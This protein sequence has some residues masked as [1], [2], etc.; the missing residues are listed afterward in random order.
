MNGEDNKLVASH[1]F[2]ASTLV[3]ADIG[4]LDFASLLLAIVAILFG[5][6]SVFAYFNFRSL[7][8]AHAREEAESI[9]AKIAEKR[10][11]SYL[12]AELPKLVDEY[13]ELVKS[14]ADDD[15]ADMIA[16]AQDNGELVD[17]AEDP[18]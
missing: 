18:K 15:I 8:K 16:Q 17:G 10:A 1:E 14:G 7:A 5:F 4:L 2:L 3:A 13:M 12:E 9:A 11:V 6:G